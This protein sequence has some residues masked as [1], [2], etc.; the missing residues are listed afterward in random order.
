MTNQP[1]QPRPVASFTFASLIEVGG[2]SPSVFAGFLATGLGLAFA[3]TLTLGDAFFAFAFA[4][5]P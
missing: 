5:M 1:I 3:A 2:H 4:A